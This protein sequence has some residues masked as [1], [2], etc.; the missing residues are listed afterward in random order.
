M[1]LSEALNVALPELPATAIRRSAPKLPPKLISCDFQQDG[2]P[3]VRAMVVGG[4]NVFTFTPQLWAMM[5]LFDGRRT[6]REISELAPATAGI[7][8]SED[9][10]REIAAIL[11]ADDFWYKTPLEMNVSATQKLSEQHHKQAAKKSKTGDL[12]NIT[13]S[14]WDPDIYLTRLN[15]KVSFV[16]TGWFTLLTLGLFVVMIS[17]F[18]GGWSEIAHDTV[19]YYTFADKSFWDIAEFW[20]LFCGLG[21]FHETAHGLTCKHFGG[22]VHRMGFMLIYLSPAFFVDITESMIYSTKWQRIAAIGAGIWVELMFCSFASIA[23]WGTPAGSPVHDFAYKIMLITGVAVVVM[24]LNP[25]IKLDGYY[26]FSQMVDLPG[27][28]EDSTGFLSS[29]V[30]KHIFRLPV[31]L[32]FLPKR[33]RTLYVTYAILSGM[34]SYLMLFAIVRLSYNILHKFSPDWAFIPALLLGL[35]IF[36][37]RIRKFGRFMKTLYLDKKDWLKARL[38]QR[39]RLLLAA[40]AL[41]FLFAPIWRESV[42]ARFVLEPQEK[43]VVRATTPGQ[44]AEVLVSEGQLISAD[45]PVVRLRNPRLEWQAAEARANLE[46]ASAR[47]VE[48]ELRHVDFGRANFEREALAGQYRS[49]AAQVAALQLASPISGVVT[50]PRAR[51]LVGSFVMAGTELLEVA[52]TTTLRARVFIPQF[53]VRKLHLGAPVSL[54]FDSFF[55]P[56][57]ATIASVAPAG[58]QIEPGLLPEVKYEGVAPPPYYAARAVLSNERGELKA[59]MAGSAKIYVSRRSLV[60]FVWDSMRDFVRVKFW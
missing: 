6:Y 16:Y 34:Y 23:W 9:E 39:G 59:G 36:K 13:M 51:D 17:I 11:D 14:A 10:L 24:N 2:N 4:T 41:V 57:Q 40:A 53:E 20:L 1:N 32:E 49:L 42:Q 35:L 55:Q 18:I 25:L 5:Q 46:T 48:A 33:R 26:L 50:T 44:V 7:E 47:T 54:R 58:S 52:D 3:M 60:G 29:W 43:A 15:E 38:T 28:K 31:E 45:T 30:R 21:F 22:G 19:K 37:S 27:L 56:R 8:L 12:S